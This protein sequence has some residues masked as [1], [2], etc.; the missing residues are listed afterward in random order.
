MSVSWDN[1]VPS[2]SKYLGKADLADYPQGRNLTIRGFKRENVGQGQNEE[3]R[4]VCY[5]QE[6]LEDETAK[7][8]VI[9]KSNSQRL[10]L[11]TGA[12]SPQEAKGCVVNVYVDPEVE[13]GGK[14]V[15]GLRIR[16][17]QDGAG[18]DFDDPVPF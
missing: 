7:P 16:A 12:E 18:K 2:E 4:T 5:W 9:N 15:G 10:Q 6:Q 1:L 8:M 17:K 13:F 3:E 11:H 14:I